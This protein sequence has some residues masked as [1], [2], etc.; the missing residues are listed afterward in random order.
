MNYNIMNIIFI[1]PVYNSEN[2]IQKS[3]QN[4]TNYL[5]NFCSSHNN[6]FFLFLL[7]MTEVMIKHYKI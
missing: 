7:L 1:L 6:V 5:I 2:I 3:L 4:L